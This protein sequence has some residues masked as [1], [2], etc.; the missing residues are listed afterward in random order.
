[1]VFHKVQWLYERHPQNQ[2][3][4]ST[5]KRDN[6]DREQTD[7][8]GQIQ[9]TGT[10]CMGRQMEEISMQKRQKEA[11][12]RKYFYSPIGEICIEDDGEAL[13]GLYLGDNAA[14]EEE[15]CKKW[16]SSGLHDLRAVSPGHWSGCFP[17]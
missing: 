3:T 1:M 10:I 17:V 16:K 6:S 2:R 7:I 13:T 11:V 14:Y 8:K 9:H 15:L 12:H 5:Y 4:Y